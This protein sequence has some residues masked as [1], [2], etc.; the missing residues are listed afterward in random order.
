MKKAFVIALS[1][2]LVGCSSASQSVDVSKYEEKISS[3]EKQLED[4][5]NKIKEL[6]SGQVTNST[7]DTPVSEKDSSQVS[8]NENSIKGLSVV[9]TSMEAM[10]IDTYEGSKNVLR[11]DFDFANNSEETATF[12]GI[13]NMKA[14]QDAVELNK[15]F[16]TETTGEYGDNSFK[17]VRP[18]GTISICIL[19]ETKSNNPIEVEV[20]ELFSMDDTIIK[21]GTYEFK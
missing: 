19:F 20:T 4:A 1:L 12:D 9:A 10:T 2:M 15:V 17:E 5:N 14:F 7:I 13:L 18:G 6:E 21:L 11:V 8:N 16:N 3:L